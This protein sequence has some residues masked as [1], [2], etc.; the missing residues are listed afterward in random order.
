MSS[1][2]TALVTRGGTGMVAGLATHDPLDVLDVLVD[3]ARGALGVW[4]VGDAGAAQPAPQ[5]PHRGPTAW[6]GAG[7]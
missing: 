1:Q 6:K 7:A 4:K 3:N 2:E 5:Q